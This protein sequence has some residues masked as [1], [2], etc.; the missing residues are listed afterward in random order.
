MALV[1][2]KYGKRVSLIGNIHCGK[3]DSG[4]EQEV[5]DSVRYTL[6]SGMP[7]GGYVFSTS[8]CI[9]T[10]MPL[11]RYELMLDIW[12]KEGNYE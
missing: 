9:D 10:G 2:Q 1:K 4:S 3:L 7:G 8:N 5:I 12:K 11:A 6:K